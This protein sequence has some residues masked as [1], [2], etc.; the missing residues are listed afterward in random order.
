MPEGIKNVNH[1]YIIQ[2]FI[3]LYR[4]SSQIVLLAKTSN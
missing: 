2:N 4:A 1:K 3:T